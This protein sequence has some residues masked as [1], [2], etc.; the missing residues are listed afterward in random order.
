MALET[1]QVENLVLFDQR[2]KRIVA[3]TFVG[4]GG[5][6]L[7]YSTW[8]YLAVLSLLNQGI[9]KP[10]VSGVLGLVSLSSMV[11]GGAFYYLREVVNKEKW[12]E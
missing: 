5:M 10:N 8:R 7:G 11:L 12:L 2:K 4:V 3:G 1:I 9:F 6:F